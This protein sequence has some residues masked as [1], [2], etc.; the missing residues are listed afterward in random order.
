M[1]KPNQLDK[2]EPVLF[3]HEKAGKKA[4]KAKVIR[5]SFTM[6]EADYSKLAEIKKKCLANGVSVKKSEL[7]R[8]GLHLLEALP[9]A[10]LKIAVGALDSVKTGRPPMNKAE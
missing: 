4:K 3:A 2:A 6:P 10:K 8:A 9:L 7:L 5:D 1:A